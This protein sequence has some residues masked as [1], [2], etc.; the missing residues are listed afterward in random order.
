METLSESVRKVTTVFLAVFLWLH[1]LFFLNFQSEFIHKC[2]QLVRLST[3][4]VILFVLLVIFSFAAGSGFWKPLRS[5]AYIYAFPFVLVMYGFYACF[6]ILRAMHR[7]FKRQDRK[8]SD[9]KEISE[10]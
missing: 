7:W 10:I 5:V 9:S 1:A 2:A 4:E 8:E 3:S 6:L